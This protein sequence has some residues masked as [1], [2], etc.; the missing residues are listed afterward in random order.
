MNIN[1]SI[2]ILTS[3]SLGFNLYGMYNEGT[4]PL[5]LLY[6]IPGN[7]NATAKD[8]TFRT[9]E[10]NEYFGDRVVTV[11]FEQFWGNDLFKIVK[12]PL[13]KDS[14]FTFNTFLNAA[15]SE[16]GE[17][18]MNIL[19]RDLKIFSNPFYEIGFGIGHFLIPLRVEFSWKL[20]HKGDNN[21]RVG[22]STFAI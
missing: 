18:S 3:S 5:Q 11:Y 17:Q 21:F 2:K 8:N 19:S 14:D 12:F 7:L 4:L 15:Y 10:F 16:I 20:N 22:I 6:S 13:L 1:S 9:L